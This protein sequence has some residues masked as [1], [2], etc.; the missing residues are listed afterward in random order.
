M[1]SSKLCG[2]HA[3]KDSRTGRCP[4]GALEKRKK[5]TASYFVTHKK[6]GWAQII[7][8]LPGPGSHFHW[9]RSYFASLVYLIFKW[10]P[11][12]S[13]ASLVL[14]AGEFTMTR[15]LLKYSAKMAIFVL[16]LP[17]E[18][19][20]HVL[21]P[22]YLPLILRY[23]IDC[24]V[25][26]T[27][28]LSMIILWWFDHFLFCLFWGFF[29]QWSTVRICF[30]LVCYK[31]KMYYCIIKILLWWYVKLTVFLLSKS[32]MSDDFSCIHMKCVLKKNKKK[33]SIS[34]SLITSTLWF[35]CCSC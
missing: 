17:W 8:N 1:Q 4:A 22:D 10:L 29:L 2:H 15:R 11:S 13:R 12:M 25:L 33:R 5:I 18:P 21:L 30:I 34:P 32:T 28:F 16:F 20:A 19:S 3:L 6:N 24:G 9:E 35:F 31:N 14:M 23:I 7:H 26:L 27:G